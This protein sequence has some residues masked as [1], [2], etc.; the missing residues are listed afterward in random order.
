MTDNTDLASVRHVIDRLIGLADNFDMAALD[1][2]Y[3]D[4]IEVIMVDVDG[5]PHISDKP[6]FKEIVRRNQESSA[7]DPSIPNITTYHHIQANSDKALVLVSRKNGL[8]GADRELLI[9]I[10][11]IFADA[12]WQVI[13]EVIFVRPD[14]LSSA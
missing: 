13:R 3:H 1:R 5:R 6:A 4:D 10:D 2:I 7:D 12:R 14:T 8:S 11:L 9:S